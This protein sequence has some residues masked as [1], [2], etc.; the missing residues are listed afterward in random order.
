MEAGKTMGDGLVAASMALRI[1]CRG[2]QLSLVCCFA[3]ALLECALARPGRVRHV[4]AP[5]NPAHIKYG[6]DKLICAP[7]HA[8]GA[9]HLNAL[10]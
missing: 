4:F 3:C 1:S 8:D 10:F 2:A 6:Q 5:V 7:S 9:I